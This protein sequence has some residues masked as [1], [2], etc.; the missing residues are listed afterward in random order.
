MLKQDIL[1]EALKLKPLDRAQLLE[2]ILESFNFQAR[3]SIDILWAEET[4]ERID[5]FNAGKITSKS[6]N[7]VFDNINK[8]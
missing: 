5:A 1:K 6:A 4:E 7:E 8:L 2:A 3:K